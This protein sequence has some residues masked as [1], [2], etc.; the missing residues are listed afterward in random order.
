MATQGRTNVHGKGGVRF[1]APY[2]SSKHK[3]QL[4]NLVST[5]IV[6]EKVT[7]TG[8]MVSD[9]IKLADRLVTYA[10]TGDLHSRRLAASVVRDY[11]ADEKK[12]LVALDKLFETIGPRYKERSGGYTRA[13]RLKSRRG[14]NAPVYLIAFVQ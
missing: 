10:K 5:L 3:S 2:T 12:G 9:L 1:K 6:E 8:G 4:R 13:L 14:D 7:V 11:I